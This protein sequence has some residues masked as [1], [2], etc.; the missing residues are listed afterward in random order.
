MTKLASPTPL[1]ILTLLFSL[2]ASCRSDNPGSSG[3]V[4]VPKEEIGKA[5]E[6]PGLKEV[7][8][9]YGPED[10]VQIIQSKR[11]SLIA[12]RYMRIS[13]RKEQLDHEYILGSKTIR[14]T[15]F[16]PDS[17]AIFNEGGGLLWMLKLG[18]KRVDLTSPD[19]RYVLSA[20]EED[21][22]LLLV[23]NGKLQC[24]GSFNRAISRY[25]IKCESR[26][27]QID[28]PFNHPG[29]MLCAMPSIARTDLL[30]AINELVVLFG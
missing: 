9:L 28:A 29:F 15:E 30:L 4:Y 10:T 1:F 3:P 20:Y 25:H 22:R 5:E 14:S 21:N 6:R 12:D 11:S 2:L 18:Q 8:I 17:I 16:R 7:T 13:C 26:E 27:I 19:G 23:E 24:T